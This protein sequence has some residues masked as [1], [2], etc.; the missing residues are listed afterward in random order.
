MLIRIAEKISIARVPSLPFN[1]VSEGVFG[2]L[3]EACHLRKVQLFEKGYLSQSDQYLVF[4]LKNDLHHLALCSS[5]LWVALYVR[6]GRGGGREECK[7]R[8]V[9]VRDDAFASISHNC[10]CT[11][12]IRV[13]FLFT[14]CIAILLM[15]TDFSNESTNSLELCY[16]T[17]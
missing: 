11:F 7:R 13:A 15:I 6:R 2:C 8:R 3:V 17:R 10:V 16:R 12:Q 5:T 4:T 1:D 14:P 9:Q